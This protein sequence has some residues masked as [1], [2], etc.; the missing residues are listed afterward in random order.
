MHYLL[1][2][3]LAVAMFPQHGAKATVHAAPPFRYVAHTPP[4]IPPPRRPVVIPA[5]VGQR[6]VNTANA[7]TGVHARQLAVHT[8]QKRYLVAC[9]HAPII[10]Y[11]YGMC[12]HYCNCLL[13]L[14]LETMALS[15][16][17]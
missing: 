4:P 13:S 5:N 6:H 14:H 1:L 9:C 2:Q 16:A 12:K 10:P 17:H 3:V 8:P 15:L 7:G 11:G